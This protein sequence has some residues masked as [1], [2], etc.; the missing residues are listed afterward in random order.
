MKKKNTGWNGDIPAYS[1]S[2][3]KINKLGYKFKLSSILAIKKTIN[4]ISK[5]TLF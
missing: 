1:Y 3:K 5:N 4:T 2:T